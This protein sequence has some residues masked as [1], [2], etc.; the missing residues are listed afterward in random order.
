MI[1]SDAWIVDSSAT[2]H[3]CS[4]LSLFTEFKAVENLTVT[5][6]N[7]TTAPIMHKGIVKLTP[8]MSL[9]HV[10]HI[11]SFKFNLI[12]VGSM[13][14]SSLCFAHF[15]PGYCVIQDHS[16]G[17]TIGKCSVF[18]NMYVFTQDDMCSSSSVS[19]C[20]SLVAD[21]DLWH[22]RLGHPSL[23]KLQSMSSSISLPKID[24]SSH[25]PVCPL[26]KQRCLPYISNNNLCSNAF[27]LVHLDVSGPFSTETIEGFR[28]FLTIVDDATRVTWIYLLKTKSSVQVVFHSFIQHV[29]TRYN[30]HIKAI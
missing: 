30:S 19:F 21:G 5:L 1:P 16:L 18:H 20:G 11:P 26:A 10:L 28:Y 8:K 22:H 7:G 23:A 3:V 14:A 25:C 17:L 6:S 12:S 15:F 2:S 24:S 13:L 29:K 9:H 27:D 4:G